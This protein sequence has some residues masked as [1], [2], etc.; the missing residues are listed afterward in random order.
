[1]A[2]LATRK[3]IVEDGWL[4]LPV[5]DVV[6]HQVLGPRGAIVEGRHPTLTADQVVQALELMQ[7]SRTFDERA[8]SLNRQ[9]R[10]G[11]FA[12]VLG[13]EACLVGSA[14]ALDPSRDWIVPQYRELP[15][16]L[17]HGYPLE[18]LVAFSFGKSDAA[19]VPEGVRIL[20]LQFSLAAQLPH[21]VGLAWGRRLL[22]HRE[23]VLAYCGEGATS[24]GDFHE[25]CNLAGTLKAAVVFFVQNNGWAISTPRRAQSAAPNLAVRALGYGFEGVVVDGNDLL[26]VHEV[27]KQAVDHALTGAGPVLIE[28]QTYR[29]GVHN[30]TDDPRR[31][32]AQREVERADR[33]DPL[34]RVRRYLR[35]LGLM[36]EAR[37]REL[38]CRAAELVESAISQARGLP[39][40][41]SADLFEHVFAEETAELARQRLAALEEAASRG[42]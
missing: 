18:R 16:L 27:T 24:E 8:T 21:A 40:Q 23:A 20:P 26:A 11:G 35:S 7:R 22:G 17:H 9:G 36:D 6:P 1:M 3:P 34:V 37:E 31:Y 39:G 33:L 2:Q 42:D 14:M 4:R 10:F 28:A 19:R 29:L 5:A 12:P 13:Q 30:M 38:E 25:A 41:T 15:A 32:R